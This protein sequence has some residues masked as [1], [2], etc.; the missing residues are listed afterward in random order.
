MLVKEPLE[1]IEHRKLYVLSANIEAHGHIGS[2]LGYALLTLAWKRDK[3]TKGGI[4]RASRNDY[5]ENL[6]RRSQDGN[7]QGQNR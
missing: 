4:P 3:T 5:R 1:V 2:C 6:G 7:I